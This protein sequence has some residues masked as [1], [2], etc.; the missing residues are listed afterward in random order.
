LPIQLSPEQIASLPA[1]FVECY[2]SQRQAYFAHPIPTYEERLHDLSQLAAMLRQHQAALVEA[3]SADFGNRSTFET[4]SY[5]LFVVLDN[6]KETKKQLRKW[7]RVQHRK[8]DFSLFPGARNRVIPQPLGIIG[9]IVPWNYPLYLSFAP[10]ISM[11]SAGNRAMVK[12]SEYS[13][14]LVSLLQKISPDF[15]PE[16]KLKFFADDNGKGVAFSK[17]PFDHLFFTG[18]SAVGKLVMA[19]AAQN[20]T[21]VT[22][23]LGGKV[24]AIV[25]P[26]YSIQTA[27]ERI[28]WVKLLNAG[29]ICTT[30]DYAFLPENSVTEF[31]TQ[32]KKLLAQRYPDL[33]GEDYTSIIAP[34]FFQRLELYSKTQNKKERN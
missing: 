17:L 18:S 21:P 15:F 33:N 29:Q 22:L 20:L 26:D 9:V 5:E 27:A 7:M 24:P 25:A 1:D 19:S 23:E 6:L 13:T 32:C 8:H 11:F 12:M 28:L 34:R 2:V 14:N 10:L 3:I 4:L 30:V 16:E 31:I